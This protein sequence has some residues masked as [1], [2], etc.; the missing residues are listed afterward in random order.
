MNKPINQQKLLVA[1]RARHFNDKQMGKQFIQNLDGPYIDKIS[2]HFLETTILSL[3]V[4]EVK[5]N[6]DYVFTN[7]KIEF[8]PVPRSKSF[9]KQLLEFIH[10]YKYVKKV[11]VVFVFLPMPL[12]FFVALYAKILNKNIICYSGARWADAPKAKKSKLLYLFYKS[13]EN[14]V[15][16]NSNIRVFNNNEMYSAY[17]HLPFTEKTKPIT[18]II[19]LIDNYKNYHEVRDSNEVFN[20]VSIGHV[21]QNKRFDYVIRSLPELL[22]QN[23]GVHY[24]IIGEFGDKNY[25]EYL[26]NLINELNLNETVTFT[27]YKKQNEVIDYLAKSDCLV[28]SSDSEGFPRVIWEAMLLSIPVMTRDLNNIVKELGKDDKVLYIG[29]DKVQDIVN[30]VKLLISSTVIKNRI[31]KKSNIYLKTVFDEKPNEQVIRLYNTFLKENN[32]KN[33]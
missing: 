17:A 8:I 26:V 19:N 13:I 30:N 24:T 9:F 3:E 33:S 5:D 29:Q 11:D 31:L 10:V 4:H 16:K 2:S 15:V 6:I 1:S 27:G 25:Y 23:I 18:N 28:L 7:R 12:S 20:L 14:F 21:L 22:S 32:D